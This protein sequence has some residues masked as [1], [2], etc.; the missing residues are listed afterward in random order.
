MVGILPLL[1]LPV[2]VLPGMDA[3]ACLRATDHLAELRRS[4]WMFAALN[5][6]EAGST[7]IG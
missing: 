7:C 6:L 3:P 4:E 1:T 5:I 2:V